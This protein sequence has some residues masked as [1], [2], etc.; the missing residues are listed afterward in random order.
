L[1]HTN[2]LANAHDKYVFD[3]I[4]RETCKFVADVLCKTCLS[5]Y[6][7]LNK[8]SLMG[9]LYAKIFLKMYMFMELCVGSHVIYDG[10]INGANGIFKDFTSTLES[11]VG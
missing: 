3:N 9:G 10:F 11:Y 6:K 5:S 1:F 8:A 2:V 4:L 7:L